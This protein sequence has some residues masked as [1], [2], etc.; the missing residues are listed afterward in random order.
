MHSEI[1]SEGG[2]SA[3]SIYSG[4]RQELVGDHLRRTRPLQ[5]TRTLE[6]TLPSPS[7]MRQTHN[8]G[9][10][11]VQHRGSPS[12]GPYQPS[13][14]YGHINEAEPVRV[15]QARENAAIPKEFLAMGH[16]GFDFL[17]TRTE[18]CSVRHHQP[19]FA[20]RREM[21]A[22][23]LKRQELSSE[24]LG[25]GVRMLHTNPSRTSQSSSDLRSCQMKNVMG[26]DSLLDPHVRHIRRTDGT[27]NNGSQSARGHRDRFQ[28]NLGCSNGSQ[29]LGLD[30]TAPAASAR[31][32]TAAPKLAELAE[33][34][35]GKVVSEEL[36]DERRRRTE[37]NFSNLFGHQ[38]GERR[39][40]IP[41]E[42]HSMLLAKSS[43]RNAFLDHRCEVSRRKKQQEFSAEAMPRHEQASGDH[44]IGEDGRK[45]F[46]NPSMPGLPGFL[47]S[48]RQALSSEQRRVSSAERPFWDTVQSVGFM[49]NSSELARRAR[50]RLAD[51]GHHSNS[52]TNGGSSNTNTNGGYPAAAAAP[53]APPG[54]GATERKRQELESNPGL[55][56]LGVGGRQL[57]TEG[58][59]TP[60]SLDRCSNMTPRSFREN[61]PFSSATCARAANLGLVIPYA[62]GISTFQ[63]SSSIS[64]SRPETPRERKLAHNRS[65]GLF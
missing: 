4:V 16:V 31:N 55:V 19:F 49:D 44:I 38:M 27:E 30:A 39:T 17:D 56:T 64:D 51:A 61:G 21:D 42:E 46:P 36:A 63:R 24:V 65:T 34:E 13:F 35:Q 23:A 59:S 47:Q 41:K 40:D 37:K 6:T 28:A 26:P 60:R 53:S 33:E 58:A 62:A 5:R 15:V 22:A 54:A 18:L 43:S 20:A 8:A 52:N 10:G 14:T 11:V 25:S 2:P 7:D 1:F 45:L 12:T 29:F 50:T 48:P 9:S 32:S 57:D 3:H